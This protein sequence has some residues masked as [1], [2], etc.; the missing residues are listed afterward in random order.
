VP[1]IKEISDLLRKVGDLACNDLLSHFVLQVHGGAW[2]LQN[3]GEGS[4]FWQ[5]PYSPKLLRDWINDAWRGLYR[6]QMG[7]NKGRP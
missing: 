5:G 1:I 6:E 2:T 4:G 3:E 7:S